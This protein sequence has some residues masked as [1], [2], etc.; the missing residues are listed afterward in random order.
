MDFLLNLL[1]FAAMV[2]GIITVA[3][4]NPRP[5]IPQTFFNAVNLRETHG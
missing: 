3:R 5:V 2:F 4:D 1:C